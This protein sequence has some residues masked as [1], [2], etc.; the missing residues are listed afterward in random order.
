MLTAPVS[1]VT[2]ELVHFTVV[3][4]CVCAT[5]PDVLGHAVISRGRGSG[6]AFA[7]WRLVVAFFPGTSSGALLK[8]VF[9][10]WKFPCMNPLRHREEK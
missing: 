5:R 1:T 6:L 7:L 3:C 4:V 9:R 10:A 8:R 2:L